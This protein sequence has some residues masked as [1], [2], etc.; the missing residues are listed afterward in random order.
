MMNLK[1]DNA[2]RYMSVTPSHKY[3]ESK[4]G[5]L[6]SE[7]VKAPLK[8][9]VFLSTTHRIK[10]ELSMN[11]LGQGSKYKG[12]T[13]EEL[14]DEYNESKLSIN[15][16]EDKPNR[17]LNLDLEALIIVEDKIW[18]LAIN[19]VHDYYEVTKAIYRT[20]NEQFDI[21][22]GDI[23]HIKTLKMTLS[24]EY[25]VVIMITAFSTDSKL[26]KVTQLQ[27]K[28]IN[29]YIHQNILLLI[30][31][32][33]GK[34]PVR[35]E[36]KEWVENLRSI[37]DNKLSQMSVK[38]TGLN[39]K[40]QP[41]LDIIR[42]NWESII[43]IVKNIISKHPN[44]VIYKK[45]KKNLQQAIL[46][47]LN[48]ADSYTFLKLRDMLHKSYLSHIKKP[49]SIK[50]NGQLP[51]LHMIGGTALQPMQ[52]LPRVKAPYLPD[53]GDERQYTL[54]LDLDETLVHYF[55]I[56]GKGKYNIRPSCQKFLKEMSELYELVIFTAA[57]QDYADWV[58]NDIDKK[59]YISYRWYRQHASQ[60]GM[61]FVK[62][63]SNLG[64]D[65][66]KIIIVDNVAENF[67]LQPDNGIFIKSW[68]D[69]TKD[70]ALSELAP[71]LKEIVVK[72]CSDVRVALRKFRDQMIEQ[73][74]K[75]ITNPKLSL[76]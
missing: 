37:I 43:P 75:G 20:I 26:H 54:V 58:L 32:I 21:L 4:M 52:Q 38:T 36:K 69:D 60:N 24:L 50:K 33:I 8:G 11:N 70:T 46:Y 9:G 16:E 40:Q 3:N 17:E 31:V 41:K 18:A 56:G 10:P 23:K 57:M 47:V 55:E 64:R 2:H 68:F 12:N 62:D 29:Y 67:Q 22:A 39:N 45:G 27:F 14:K 61:T 35:E 63:L 66:S 74:S 48:N 42:Q 5:K 1:K 73:I 19:I 28:N 71:L 30:D 15:N 25:I 7:T 53:M 13:I 59:K 34:L 65:L 44:N 76:D 72:K 51:P 49:K 6:F